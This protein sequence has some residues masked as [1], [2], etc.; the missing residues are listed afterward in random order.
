MSD[1]RL[2]V[3][4][5]D[6]PTLRQ[7]V[8]YAVRTALEDSDGGYVRFVYAQAPDLSR[9]FDEEDGDVDL[10]VGKTDALLNRIA[11]WAREDAGTRASDLTV[12]TAYVGTDEY[13]F[14]PEDLAA[15]LVAEAEAHDVA[16]I[17]L[18]PEYNPGVGSPLLRPLEY[19]LTRFGTVTV[20]EAPVRAQTRRSPLVVRAT[21]VQVGGLFFVSFV[22]YQLLA[23]QLYWFD[24]V[25][26]VVS[27]TIV[28][29][30]LSR[31]TFHRD[32]SAATVARLARMVVYVPYLLV[33]IIRSNV[34]IAAV[35]LHPRL[36]IEPRL[37]RV[38]TAVWGGL[39]VTTLANSITLTPGT[40]S[41][42]VDGRTLTV[43]TLVPAAR[44]DLF[45]GG[46]ERA[47]RFVF[48]GREAMQLSSPRE[49]NDT[50]ILQ[51]VPAHVD[52]TTVDENGET[53]GNADAD[54]ETSSDTDANG[55]GNGE[56]NENGAGDGN[57]GGEPT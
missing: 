56:R 50:E 39:P 3:P 19:E 21:P 37:T 11:V 40:L 31:V 41:V 33:Q 16:R 34:L 2:L 17:V 23:G 26:G 24:I 46:L 55:D 4:V 35:I 51:P 38:R 13:L 14:S 53:N 9:E 54:P 47:V 43:H 18:D 57:D 5:S 29:V 36:P 15:S 30:G 28:A 7:T 48:Y 27:A 1:E 10:A 20:E 8:G 32:P 49:R 44:E 12:E 45:D 42:R 25:T 22:F 6:S 52:G